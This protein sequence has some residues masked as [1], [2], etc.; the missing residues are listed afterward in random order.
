M[1]NKPIL[2]QETVKMPDKEIGVRCFYYDCET[3]VG[4]SVFPLHWHEHLEILAI[5]TGG[6]EIAIEGEKRMFCAGDIAVISPGQLHSCY[7]RF[8]NTTLY[9]LMVDMSLFRSRYVETAEERYITPLIEGKVLLHT[10]VPQDQAVMDIVKQSYTASHEK[11]KAYQLQL[12]ALMF[13]LIYLLYSQHSVQEETPLSKEESLS[14]ERVNI[15]LRYINNHYAEKIQLDDL[16]DQVHINKYYICRIFQKCTGMTFLDY[17]NEVRVQKAVE[18]L[19]T[20]NE[21]V[22]AIAFA[23][24]F[25]DINYF[26]RVFKQIMKVSPTMVRKNASQENATHNNSKSC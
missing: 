13:Q 3:S 23:T 6:M 18:M 26:S 7:Y 19:L 11:K 14:R 25:H 15:I 17:I 1:I 5:L 20:T 9:C 16:V 12:K 24:G 2:Y 8:P 22:T 10:F 4:P 21:S